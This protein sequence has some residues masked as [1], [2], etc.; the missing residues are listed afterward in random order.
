MQ[1]GPGLGDGGRVAQHA[2]GALHLGKVATRND[3]GWLVVDAD[4]ESGGTPVDKLDGPLGLDGGN[5]CVDVLGDNVTTVQHAAGHVLAVTRIALHHLVGRLEAGVGDLSNRQLLVV[6]FLGR[7]D[8]G[9]CGQREVNTWVGHQVGLE[10]GQ[11]NIE[12]TVEPEGGSDGGDNLTDQPVQVCVCRALNVEVPTADVVDS[13]VVDHEGAV[14]VLQGGM[15]GQNGVVWFNDGGGNLRSRVDGELK[16][17]FLSV[18]NG[19]TLHE[20]GGEART[21]TTTEG[22]EDEESLETSALVSQLSDP[23]ENKVDDLLTDGVMT[24]GV[25]IS[26]VLLAG[27]QLLGV[28]QLAIKFQP[29]NNGGFQVDEDGTWNVLAGAGL[30]E[31]GIKRVVT[32]TD[33]LVG[34]HLTVGLD[35]VLQAV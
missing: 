16:L 29:T 14:R 31:E 24:T 5:G 9:I 28:E 33:G 7:D 26:G 2:H 4:L 19:Q 1:A 8:W 27:N 15:G 13:L 35:A 30:A 25:V 34:G 21:G 11:V 17:G 3:G 23:V 10:L 6:G 22:V 32:T 18:V 12:S 20:Q